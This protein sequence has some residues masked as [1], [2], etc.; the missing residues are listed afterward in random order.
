MPPRVLIADD[1]AVARHAV[2]KRVRASGVEVVE[3]ESAEG[4][5]RADTSQ[6]ACALLDLELGDGD[7]TEVAIALRARHD[8]LPIA[9]FS[10]TSS[11]DLLARA[12]ELGPVFTKPTELAVAVEWVRKKAQK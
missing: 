6:I 7:G 1:S 2:A 4:A 9:F 10:A 5:K 3:E 11:E 8:T 12:I